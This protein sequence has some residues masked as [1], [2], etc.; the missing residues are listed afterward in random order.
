MHRIISTLTILMLG[1]VVNSAV[2]AVEETLQNDGFTTGA[3]VDFQA[4]FVAGEVAAAR[5][6]PTIACPCA[7]EKISLLFGGTTSTREMGVQIWEDAAGDDAP[8]SLLFTGDVTLI[9]SNVSLNEI[10]LSLTPIIVNG[11]FR[12]GLEFGHN[13]LPSVATGLDGTIDASAN[14]I[15]ADVAVG[16]LFWFPSATL[17]V[18]GDFVI[19]A[20]IDNLVQADTDG[21]GVID[22]Q[23]NCTLIANADQRDTNGDGFGNVCDP[24]LDNNGVVNF[25]DVSLWVPFFLTSAS[26]QDFNGD[27]FVNFVDYALFPQFFL[28]PP[29]PSGVAP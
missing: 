25:G 1:V 29:G 2:F 9:G 26:D 6:V 17:G 14:F 7:V 24:D 23:D 22:F 4:G 11:P 27:G 20:T 5:F 3:A 12:V 21:D 16:V 13:G 10:D 19:R 18:T 28:Q 15:L 8:G